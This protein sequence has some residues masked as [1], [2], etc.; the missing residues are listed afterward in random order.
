MIRWN[1]TWKERT[2][3]LHVVSYIR[4]L[5]HNS[6]YVLLWLPPLLMDLREVS[7]LIHAVSQILL[8]KNLTFFLFSSKYSPHH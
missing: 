7:N 5:L 8:S 3:V 1:N 4:Y 6:S 2:L